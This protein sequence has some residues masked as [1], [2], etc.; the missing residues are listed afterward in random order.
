MGCSAPRN[1]GLSSRAKIVWFLIC[2][3]LRY[4]SSANTFLIPLYRKPEP[5]SFLLLPKYVLKPSRAAGEGRAI[6][7]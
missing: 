1:F 7:F 6:E 3:I 5:S 4:T 2:M